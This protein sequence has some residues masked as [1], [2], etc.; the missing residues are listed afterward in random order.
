MTLVTEAAIA[1]VDPLPS[2]R[3]LSRL[4]NSQKGAMLRVRKLLATE[5]EAETQSLAMSETALAKRFGEFL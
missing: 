2:T 1:R 3:G 5:I 4:S